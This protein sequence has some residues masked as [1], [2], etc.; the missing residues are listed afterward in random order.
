[1]DRDPPLHVVVTGASRGL[2]RALAEAF[3]AD[4][5]VVAATARSAS[6]LEGLSGPAGPAHPVAMDLGDGSSVDAAADDL[7]RVLDARVDLLVNNAGVLGERAILADA[8]MDV[9]C[10]DLHVNVCG[11]LRLTQR[12]LPYIPA[13]GAVVMV[14]SGAAGRPTWAGYALSKLALD[15][16]TRMFREESRDRGIRF[17]G[18]NPGG[19]R[20]GMRAAAY[21]GEDPAT[22]P[23][24]E[25][26]LPVFRAIARGADPGVRVEAQGWR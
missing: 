1:V 13:G 11:T 19:I 4:G 18:V 24:P 7:L 9:L 12:L 14:T 6:S 16:A 2:G 3:L 26:V 23:A 22:L 15:A 5:H 17:V 8:S 25:E 20:T 21:P 10:R